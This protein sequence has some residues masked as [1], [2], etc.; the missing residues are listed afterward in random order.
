MNPYRRILLSC[1]SLTLFLFCAP[2]LFAQ[3]L[4]QT[5]PQPSI[6]PGRLPENTVFY[7]LWR[8]A[9]APSAR[10]A[11][12]LYALWDDPDFAPARNE[13]FDNFVSKSEKSPDTKPQLS[14]EELSEFVT[15]LENPFSIGYVSEPA[16][17]LA[18]TRL[19]DDKHKWN[20]IFLI[21]DRS[22]KEGI[23]A[24]A[25][26]RLRATE[27]DPPTIST[28]TIAGV[29]ALKLERKT[30]TSYWVDSGRYLFTSGEPSVIEQLLARM[31]SNAIPA[32][33]LANN[34]SFKEAHSVLGTG[35]LEYFV[36]IANVTKLA[37]DTS[38]PGGVRTG[39]VL[40]AMKV[41]ALHS[42]SGQVVLDGAKT[43]MQLAF[44]GD[45]SVGTIFDIWDAGQTNPTSLAYVSPSAIS[46]REA[47]LNL[48]GIYALAMRV[49]K[50]FTAKGDDDKTDMIEAMAR[51]KLGMSVADA[52]N[53]FTGEMGYL[54]YD[55]SFDLSK[56]AYFIGVR[57]KENSLKIIRHVFLNEISSDLD[58]DNVTF[59]KLTF[60]GKQKTET[61]TNTI[62]LAVTPD[63]I[64]VANKREVFSAP[65]A[66]RTA[67]AQP[68]LL[69]HFFAERAKYPQTINGLNFLDLQKFDWQ[70][71]KDLQHGTTPKK[72][73]LRSGDA[74]QNLPS[75][76]KSF[77]DGIDPKVFARHLHF[78]SGYSW[79]D[80][81]GIHFDGWID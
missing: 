27:K 75:K 46:Y 69:A 29:P 9:P 1:A 65:L 7:V 15:L 32:A 6:D 33:S 49:A 42:V 30:G 41:N 28:M 48:P 12:S 2:S 72:S 71:I 35:I 80:A 4:P 36:N 56:N 57:N 22:G 47:Q 77:L 19:I 54:Q 5:P 18:N 8:G 37:A 25:V 24:K 70:S 61:A 68:S 59:L 43:R 53:T 20:G 3:G 21:Y 23:L 74:E 13:L 39:P 11:N 40:D 73:A 10:T 16:K 31:K 45:T 66:Q 55:S 17:S 38:G 64:L 79:K 51:L 63:M 52:L 78:S 26:L 34:V 50:S 44:L 60:G 58:E 81:N 76:A 14:R 67:S 62:R